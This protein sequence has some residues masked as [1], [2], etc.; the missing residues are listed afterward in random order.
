[1]ACSFLTI[2]GL[3]PTAKQAGHIL[4]A[5][6]KPQRLAARKTE[7]FDSK[8]ITVGYR[9]VEAINRSEN[10][11]GCRALVLPEFRPS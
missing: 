10:S 2:G 11:I 8:R 5:G 3:P 7:S 9:L 4:L 6:A 1:M